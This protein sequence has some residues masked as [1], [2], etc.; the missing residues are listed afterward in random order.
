MFLKLTSYGS[1][2]YIN[3]NK[4]V[5]I[6]TLKDGTTEL[7]YGNGNVTRVEESISEIVV[8]LNV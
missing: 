6:Y 7:S 4:V 8:M 1:T 3:M 5:E 2:I